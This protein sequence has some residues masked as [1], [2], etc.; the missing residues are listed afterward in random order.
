MP[1]QTLCTIEAGSTGWLNQETV[2]RVVEA[3]AKLPRRDLSPIAEAL[4]AILDGDDTRLAVEEVFLVDEDLYRTARG[5]R[6]IAEVAELARLSPA[7]VSRFEN[8]RVAELAPAKVA[9]L[10]AMYTGFANEEN[11]TAEDR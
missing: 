1:R 6:T 7:T 8:C 2:E 5:Q 10:A 4:R 11:L 3:Y 9:L